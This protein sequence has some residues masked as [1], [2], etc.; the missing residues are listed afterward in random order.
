MNLQDNITG[1]SSKLVLF[2]VALVGFLLLRRLFLCGRMIGFGHHAEHVIG[3]KLVSRF[4]HGFASGFDLFER[5]LERHVLLFGGFLSGLLDF[6]LFLFGVE[7]FFGR[8]VG[9][10]VFGGVLFVCFLN[11][12]FVGLLLDGRLDFHFGSFVGAAQSPTSRNSGV[13]LGSR[14]SRRAIGIGDVL[15]NARLAL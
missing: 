10:F 3:G 12:R 6:A 9:G 2:W 1:H 15:A 5:G 13:A 4:N 7:F 8:Q 11:G 14:S